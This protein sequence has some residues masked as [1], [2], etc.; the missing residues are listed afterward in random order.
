MRR[1]SRPN[2]VVVPGFDPALGDLQAGRLPM[3]PRTDSA[4]CGG[5]PRLEPWIGSADALPPLA[6]SHGTAS[7]V[8]RANSL[9]CE[10]TRKNVMPSTPQRSVERD[11]MGAVVLNHNLRCSWPALPICTNSVSCFLPSTSQESLMA[12]GLAGKHPET[13]TGSIFNVVRPQPASRIGHA[14][15]ATMRALDV[16]IGRRTCVQ[17]HC[18]GH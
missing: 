3:V 8:R 9:P 17:A 7:T 5:S 13:A 2:Q 11:P 6:R 4:P 15:I 16:F 10:S 18:G 12:C 14:K 1:Y